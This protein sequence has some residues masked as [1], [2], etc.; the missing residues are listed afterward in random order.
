[1]A[2]ILWFG[3][4]GEEAEE[5]DPRGGKEGDDFGSLCLGGRETERLLLVRSAA[6]ARRLGD[7]IVVVVV[8][9]HACSCLRRRHA[10][11]A[12]NHKITQHHHAP[13]APRASG[14]QARA[15]ARGDLVVERFRDQ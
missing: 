1:V 10:P 3:G 15:L 11:L 9:F 14:A 12:F 13:R 6:T 8:M 5:G 7:R 2:V 4:S